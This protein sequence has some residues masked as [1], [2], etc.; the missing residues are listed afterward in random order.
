M[1]VFD[2]GEQAT[3]M[4]QKST[5]WKIPSKHLRLPN[6][7]YIHIVNQQQNALKF[8]AVHHLLNFLHLGNLS[9]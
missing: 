5:I 2:V 7:H 1:L 3:K 9:Q 6:E 4:Y 8:P